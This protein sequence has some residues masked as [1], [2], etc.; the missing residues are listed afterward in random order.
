[1]T[2]EIIKQ[3]KTKG[4]RITPAR[5]K[6]IQILQSI[7]QPISAIDLLNKLTK[8]DL[9]VNKTTV[10]RELEFLKKEGII[11]TILFEDHTAR[12]ELSD[13]D[14]HHHLICDNCGNIADVTLSEQALIKQVSSVSSF[15][16]KRHSLEF[17]GLCSNCQ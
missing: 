15:L 16:V 10:Y 13:L 4:F 5:T 3:L 2:N 17:F 14:H 8:L 1:M 7:K 12:Y 9:K 6:I 11:Q